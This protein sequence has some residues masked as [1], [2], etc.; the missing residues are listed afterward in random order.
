MAGSS[1][2]VIPPTPER[3][4][5]YCRRLLPSFQEIST[6]SIG[7]EVPR[8]IRQRTSTPVPDSPCDSKLSDSSDSNDSAADTD[9]EDLGDTFQQHQPSQHEEKENSEGTII[10][11]NII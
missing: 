10:A 9:N 5:S 2:Y 1:R 7:N 4:R 6:Q 8:W 3:D 11:I